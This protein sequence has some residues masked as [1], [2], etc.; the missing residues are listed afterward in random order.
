MDVYSAL[1]DPKT[2]DVRLFMEYFL[3]HPNEK[4]EGEPD[5]PPNDT[6]QGCV[7]SRF[8]NFSEKVEVEAKNVGMP[9]A[10]LGLSYRTTA[11][12]H[13]NLCSVKTCA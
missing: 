3:N 12:S 5:P 8:R 11:C 4:E 1:R 10:L 2:G 9:F 7:F 6:F 13:G